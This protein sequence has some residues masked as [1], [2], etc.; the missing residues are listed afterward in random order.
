MTSIATIS[1][2][3]PIMIGSGTGSDVMHRI[4]APMTGGM[5]SVLVLSLVVLP[6]IYGSVIILKGRIT[7]RSPNSER[8]NT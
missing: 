7:N 2:L 5:I 1:G 3:V 8:E 6:V 4:A